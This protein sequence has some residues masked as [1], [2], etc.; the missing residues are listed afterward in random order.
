MNRRLADECA[1]LLARELVALIAHNYRDEEL[2]D[3]F[4]AFRAACRDG[5]LRYAVQ[6]ERLEQR[7]RPLDN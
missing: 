7:L 2:R 6:A 5:L 4:E 3:L 1:F